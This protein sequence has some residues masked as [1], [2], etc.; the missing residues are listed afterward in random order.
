MSGAH[1]GS[2]LNPLSSRTPKQRGKKKSLASLAAPDLF[3]D[4]LPASCGTLAPFR[5][6]SHSQPQSSPWDLTSKARAS[7][8]SSHLSRHLSRQATRAGESLQAP[9]LPAGLS[10]FAL[11]TPVAA[12]PS[13][14]LK[15]PPSAT[16]SLHSRRC[17]LVCGNL[18]SFTAP[19][20]WCRSHPYSFVSVFLFSCALPRYVGSFLPFGRSEVFCQLSVGVL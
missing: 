17:F 9:I 6:C 4:T 12:L 15:L 14:A 8:P 11:C 7:A 1:L 16:R 18:S 5:L 20:H 10:C 3:L 2:A 13:V 19:S